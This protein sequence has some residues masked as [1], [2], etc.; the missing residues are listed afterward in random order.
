MEMEATHTARGR[1]HDCRV[2]HWRVDRLLAVLARMGLLFED[3]DVDDQGR[4]RALER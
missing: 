3:V 4:M 1:G 2:E